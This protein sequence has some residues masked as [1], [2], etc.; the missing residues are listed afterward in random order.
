[1]GHQNT[2]FYELQ[3]KLAFAIQRQ[4]LFFCILKINII[5]E[6]RNVNEIFLYLSPK[7]PCFALSA[8]FCLFLF[9]IKQIDMVEYSYAGLNWPDTQYVNYRGAIPPEGANLNETG[10]VDFADFAIFEKHWLETYCFPP[11]YCE[12][13]NINKRDG[14]N[15]QDLYEFTIDRLNSN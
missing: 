7:L 8:Y 14:V 4:L 2:L 12:G 13:T 10:L 6:S 11:L 9:F 5:Q 3:I 15:M 1:M